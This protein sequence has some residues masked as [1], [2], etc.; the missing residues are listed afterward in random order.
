[1][2]KD[3]EM[4]RPAREERNAAR[5]QQVLEAAQD[6]FL[7]RG[8]HGASMAEISAAAGMSVGHIYHYFQNKDAIIAAIIEQGVQHIADDFAEIGRGSDIIAGMIEH[9]GAVVRRQLDGKGPSLSAEI[10]AEASRNA[11]VRKV[12]EEADKKVHGI[13]RDTIAKSGHMPADAAT[14]DARMELI[15]AIFDGLEMRM[16][17]NPNLPRDAVL[18][19]LPR[20]MR[21]L[22]L[23]RADEDAKV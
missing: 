22:L 1:M 18:A 12:L 9:A 4:P 11:T 8:F 20:L 15:G 6:C 14:L 19:E 3:K 13:V 16:I 5:R 7:R 17:R 10:F 23:G 2:S 21:Y